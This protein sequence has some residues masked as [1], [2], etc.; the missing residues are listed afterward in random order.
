MKKILVILIFSLYTIVINQFILINI[1]KSIFKISHTIKTLILLFIIYLILIL[2]F[3]FMVLIIP[4]P[5]LVLIFFIFLYIALFFTIYVKLD[6]NKS[7]IESFII[8]YMLFTKNFKN[9]FKL[10]L[11][12]GLALI[13]I[14]YSMVIVGLFT[15]QIFGKISIIMIN[16]L[17]YFSS[18]FLSIIWI[19][20]YI[21][22]INDNTSVY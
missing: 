10:L 2:S 11:M 16:I 4:I 14:T 20:F 19:Y 1:K 3:L 15:T 9:I 13:L 5:D 8:G 17:F 22:I 18:Y 12:H 21:S 7:F 6:Y